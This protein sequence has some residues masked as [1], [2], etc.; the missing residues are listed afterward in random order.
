MAMAFF[1]GEY[2][3]GWM[4][5]GVCA[6]FAVVIVGLWWWRF[7]PKSAI[8]PSAGYFCVAVLI[9]AFWI[10]DQS[11]VI[12]S[13]LAFAVSLPWSGLLLVA[14]MFLEFGIP[15]WVMP[16]SVLLNTALIYGIAR[17]SSNR[18]LATQ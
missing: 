7:P 16:L 12:L 9:C 15:I 6:L 17:L 13:S 3:I 4:A 5:S 18:R 2:I 14:M 10:S 11:S 1:H 8:L